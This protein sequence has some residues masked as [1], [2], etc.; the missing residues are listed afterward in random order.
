M[1]VSGGLNAVIPPYMAP[2]DPKWAV[3]SFQ[4]GTLN[5]PIE[6]TIT[7]TAIFELAMLSL[8]SEVGR[9]SLDYRNFAFSSSMIANK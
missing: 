1:S 8:T 7:V 2:T 4:A 9:K 5:G 6:L 3:P